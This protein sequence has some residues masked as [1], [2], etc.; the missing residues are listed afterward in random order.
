MKMGAPG[1]SP[2]GA[3]ESTNHGLGKLKSFI[4]CRLLPESRQPR[5]HFSSHIAAFFHTW[6]PVPNYS[7]MKKFAPYLHPFDFPF[8]I[9]RGY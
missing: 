6:H 8:T 9:P 1:A 2:L 7:P 5:S 4:P 3:W